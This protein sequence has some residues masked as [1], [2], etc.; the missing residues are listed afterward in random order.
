MIAKK[1]TV[2]LRTIQKCLIYLSATSVS[3]GSDDVYTRSHIIAKSRF[4][5][6]RKAEKI[7]VPRK[8]IQTY[9]LWRQ[10]PELQKT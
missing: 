10:Q 6:E 7:F 3:H 2:K 4:E 1:V 8:K 9:Q 5:S